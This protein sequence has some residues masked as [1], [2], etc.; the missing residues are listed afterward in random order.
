MSLQVKWL[1]SKS[2]GSHSPPSHDYISRSVRSS[3]WSGGRDGAAMTAGSHSDSHSDE[4]S[5]CTDRSTG[6]VV[7]VRDGPPVSRDG[8]NE[9][10]DLDDWH[11]MHCSE[12]T[13][14]SQMQTSASVA[15]AV[16]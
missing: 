8:P 1:E 16:K 3:N 15:C 13:N 2:T 6:V 10:L 5:S 14:S 7:T 9:A 11:Q 12:E 4:T